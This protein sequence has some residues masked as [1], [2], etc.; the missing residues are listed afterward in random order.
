MKIL[1]AGATGNTGLR[2]TQELK[3][4]GHDPVALVRESSDTSALPDGVETRLGD[5]ADL[6]QGVT[7]GC[8]AVV[9]A[10][11]SGGDTSEE[12]TDKIDRDGA[13]RLIELCEQSDV[14]R[15]VMLSSVG[16]DD[17]DP[18]GELAHYLKAKHDADE[19]LKQSP[20]DYAILR[21]VSL[22]DDG[23]TGE[24][25][26]GD[27]VDPQAKAARGDVAVLLAD[28]TLQDEWTGRI[29]LMQST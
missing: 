28:A 16:A 5:L 17:P 21:P 14:R 4:R 18:E 24:V 2:L 13:I 6:D 1:V 27:E 25:V 29:A 12:M 22:T 15:F 23:P 10:A 26:L 7:H 20:L 8:E 11:G 3:D 9:F 19:R